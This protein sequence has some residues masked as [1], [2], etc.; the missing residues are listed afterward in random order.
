MWWRVPRGGKTWKAAQGPQNRAN[1]KKLIKAG[2]VHAVLAFAGAEPVGWCSFGPRQT[3][4]RLERVKALK[5]DVGPAT[6]S[7]ICF[8]IRARWRSHGVA[9]R[10]LEAATQRAFDRGANE[11]EGY[12]VVPQKPTAKVPSAFAWTGVPMLFKRDGYRSIPRPGMSRPLFL[13]KRKK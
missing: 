4:P 11:V 9:T 6:W 13:K 3:F 1:F 7:I 2:K 12:P 10:L 8:Y 5:R